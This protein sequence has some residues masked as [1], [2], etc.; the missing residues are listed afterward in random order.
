M[1]SIVGHSAF[2]LPLT[3]PRK[4]IPGQNY[5]VTEPL[6]HNQGLVKIS[7]HLNTNIIATNLQ[8]LAFKVFLKHS[9]TNFLSLRP[10]IS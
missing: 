10:R 9:C 3:G 6:M 2:P 8:I 4:Q 5:N 7:I 1:L